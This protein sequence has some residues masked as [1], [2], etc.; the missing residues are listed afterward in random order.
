MHF[1]DAV[2]IGAPAP[3][4]WAVFTDIER[5]P[6]W[7]A[8]VR[9]ARFVRGDRIAV[10]ARVRIKQPR[11]AAMTWEVTSVD[12]GVSWTWVARSPGVRTTAA[13]RL[14]QL[15][16]DTTRVEQT[17]EHRGPFA[18]VASRLTAGLTRR[19]LAMEGAGLRARCESMR[20]PRFAA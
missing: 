3:E 12:P 5:W 18:R 15:D 17:I 10:G 7:T 4:V 9:D 19:Y 8:S 14:E 2:V 16:D 6:E 11:L 1:S 20:D 13:H